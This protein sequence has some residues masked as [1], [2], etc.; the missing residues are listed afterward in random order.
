MGSKV[1]V[2][3]SASARGDL[4]KKRFGFPVLVSF[5]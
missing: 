3:M 1:M 4:N 5:S 2:K